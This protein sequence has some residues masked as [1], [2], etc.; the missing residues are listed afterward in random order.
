MNF[1]A[2]S[3]FSLAVLWSDVLAL[4]MA[5]AHAHQ[6]KIA[7][8]LEPFR[9]LDTKRLANQLKSD[10]DLKSPGG[11]PTPVKADPLQSLGSQSS[12][13]KLQT[14][15]LIGPGGTKAELNEPVRPLHYWENG[16]FDPMLHGSIIVPH[17]PPPPQDYYYSPYPM[18]PSHLSEIEP[19]ES[20]GELEVTLPGVLTDIAKIVRA[21]RI[22]N[23]P[24]IPKNPVSVADVRRQNTGDGMARWMDHVLDSN[25]EDMSLG[26]DGC[27]GCSS[28]RVEFSDNVFKADNRRFDDADSGAALSI[29]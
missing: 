5:A 23:S 13:A 29:S 28:E 17:H 9:F 7:I 16:G 25:L 11:D 20:V 21:Q 12:D 1:L 27:A 19:D 10:A 14:I 15:K 8:A 3:F 26:G 22:L 24:P 6:D 4:P 2:F 18:K